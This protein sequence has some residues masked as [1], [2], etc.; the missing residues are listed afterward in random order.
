MG[1]YKFDLSISSSSTEVAFVKAIISAITGLD[2][3][4]TCIDDPDTEYAQG[5]SYKP[6][7]RF[8]LNSVEFFRFQ[9]NSGTSSRNS[10]FAFSYTLND[11]PTSISTVAYS[12]DSSD[13]SVS[14]SRT[15][16]FSYIV[17]G[18]FIAFCIAK[19]YVSGTNRDHIVFSC[20]LSSN[21]SYV[22][23]YMNAYSSNYN[24]ETVF[25]LSER[26]FRSI[27]GGA[28]NNMTFLSRFTYKAQPGKV[29]Y[30]KNSIY[31][32]SGSK[33][34]DTT[35]LYDCSEVASGSTVSVNDGAYLAVGPHQ[36]VKVS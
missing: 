16:K 15:Y 18:D 17:S 23:S 4:I 24:V 1:S 32:S 34:F 8:C 27:S 22:S 14:T 36:L 13:W 21:D 6:K 29:D 35:A 33:I 11:T 9:R 19:P 10:S 28:I 3:R 12:S 20:I 30:I 7:F 2:D 25:N 31:T 5:G 26:T